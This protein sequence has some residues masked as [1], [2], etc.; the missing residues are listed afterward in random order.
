MLSAVR[1]LDRILRGEATSLEAIRDNRFDI[2][3]VGISFILTILGMI[4][5]LCMGTFSLTAS[6]SNQN[7][8]ILATTVKVPSLF[9]LTLIVTFPSLYVFNALFGSRLNLPTMLRLM[10]GSLAV[11][12]AVL[13]SIGPIVAF[14]S[15]SSTSY[16]F[17][18]I[19]NVAVFAISGFLGLGFLIQTLH[20]LTIAN[21][22]E[23]QPPVETAIPVEEA[24]VS[25]EGFEIPPLPVSRSA[26]RA[27]DHR[28]V[29]T[30]VWLIFRVWVLVFG[31]VGSQMAWVLRPFIGAPNKEF[32]WFRPT[33]GNFFEA[34]WTQLG[35]LFG[36]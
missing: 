4:Y 32:A 11:T 7:M 34:V 36:W 17:M 20:R 1:K 22:S 25:P 27:P 28:K 19:L 12:L 2:P 33:G 16:A 21:Q 26:I 10:I 14:F 31:L 9:L 35:R 18:V 30:G 8:Q 13:S 29:A 6:G 3:I 15:V 5:G 24:V 23:P